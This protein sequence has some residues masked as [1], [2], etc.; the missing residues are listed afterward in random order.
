M[1]NE[2]ILRTLAEG[3][4]LQVR[5]DGKWVTMSTEGTLRRVLNRVV[6]PI[7][8]NAEFRIKPP[9][10]IAKTGYM[11][12]TLVSAF[13]GDSDGTDNVRITCDSSNYKLL[14]VAQ[15]GKPSP[16]K[17]E[18]LLYTL[19]DQ[20]TSDSYRALAQSIQVVLDDKTK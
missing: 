17:M 19:L 20:L 3:K 11:S 13:N 18:A 9:P 4:E 8:Y 16:A 5:A 12:G 15:F 10:T 14:E 2:E 1:T 6:S 7:E